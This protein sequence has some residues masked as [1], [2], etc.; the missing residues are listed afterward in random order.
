MSRT[1]NKKQGTKTIIYKGF[2]GVPAVVLNHAD[3]IALSPKA[4]KLFNDIGA[5]YNG[6]NN[7]DLCASITPMMKRGWRSRDQLS[8]A[9]KELIARNWIIQTR[10]GGLNMGPNLYAIT[11]QPIDEC[12]GKLDVQPTT[13][14]PRKLKE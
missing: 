11:W 4:V 8:K 5:Q 9:I 10:Q 12:G 2:F 6:R 13:G 14:A 1:T 3:Y 7:G